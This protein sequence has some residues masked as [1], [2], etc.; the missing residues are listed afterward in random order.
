MTVAAGNVKTGRPFEQAAG[1][2]MEIESVKPDQRN[3]QLSSRKS[4]VDIHIAKGV[5]LIV[6][7]RSIFRIQHD[8]IIKHP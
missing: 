6:P 8:C 5:P 1:N 4:T 3:E 7:F 2:M